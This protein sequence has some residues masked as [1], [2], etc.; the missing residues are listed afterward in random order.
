MK[1][2][3]V[4]NSV[5]LGFSALIGLSACATKSSM[6]INESNG[7]VTLAESHIGEQY[8]DVILRATGQFAAEPQ[9]EARKISLKK[10]RKAF[11]YDVCGFSPESYQFS[12]APLA[13]VVYHFVEKGLV[14][15]D[16]RAKGEAALLNDVKADMQ[17]LFALST[18][19]A[20]ELGN[21][22][23]QWSGKSLLAGV[24]AG[25]GASSGNIHVRLVDEAIAKDAPWLAAE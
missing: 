7:R 9:C 15:V 20:T 25:V 18:K 10:Q 12:G 16:V 21:D 24:R 17:S 6:S 23:Y 5:V 3:V 13:E 11:D 22:S 2:R 1:H 19:Q 14:R 4:L 8:D